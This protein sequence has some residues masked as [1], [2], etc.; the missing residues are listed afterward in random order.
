MSSE[1][2][3]PRMGRFVFLSIHL[4]L[5]SLIVLAGI[6]AVSLG[7]QNIEGTNIDPLGG[8]IILISAI[9]SIYIGVKRLHD[10]DYCGW[11]YLVFLLP[12]IGNILWLLLFFV[13]GTYGANRYGEATAKPSKI[14]S[15]ML[16]GSL[17]FL[18]AIIVSY[19]SLMP[20]EVVTLK[21][22]Q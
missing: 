19:V 2:T 4:F 11:W 13:P 18:I 14:Y 7:L 12:L 16:Y 22:T 5:G 6:L 1:V 3:A 20:G 8:S 21:V 15:V 10:L 17:I 9:I